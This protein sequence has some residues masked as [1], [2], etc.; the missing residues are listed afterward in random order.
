MRR[1]DIAHRALDFALTS[2]TG[3]LLLV[4]LSLDWTQL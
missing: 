2:L 4:G 3:G 1:I